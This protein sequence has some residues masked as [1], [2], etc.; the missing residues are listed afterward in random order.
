[1]PF[2]VYLEIPG[3]TYILFYEILSQIQTFPKA[4]AFSHET[5]FD[6]SLQN[7]NKT[8]MEW[9]PLPSPALCV[10]ARAATW[11]SR[12]ARGREAFLGRTCS[13]RRRGLERKGQGSGPEG[14]GGSDPESAEKGRE[15]KG[16]R[17][18]ELS[19]PLKAPPL[20]GTLMPP[21]GRSGGPHEMVQPHLKEL[22][23]W[24]HSY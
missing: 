21:S 16:S 5:N 4:T 2:E 19:Q 23:T 6:F 24:N 3:E 9:I 17:G 10:L 15:G 13:Q 22:H 1:M 18:T 14:A 8:H 20:K 12:E 7:K 11:F